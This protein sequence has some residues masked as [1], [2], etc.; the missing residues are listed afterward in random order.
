LRGREWERDS[1]R[2]KRELVSSE[3]SENQSLCLPESGVCRSSVLFFW[4]RRGHRRAAEH[5]SA[6]LFRGQRPEISPS[7]ARFSFCAAGYE[8]E[9]LSSEGGV[10]RPSIVA[11]IERASASISVF[12][13][14]RGRRMTAEHR[15]LHRAPASIF[16]F[17]LLRD[18]RRAVERSRLHRAQASV[19]VFCLS[20][21]DVGRPSTNP[22]ASYRGRRRTVKY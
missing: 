21:A 3:R 13:S 10:G 4:L 7:E 6:G 16:T 14:Y 9:G 8:S 17:C 5:Q 20:E 2:A 15:R 18:C 12:A 11:L 19:S 22:S 1:V